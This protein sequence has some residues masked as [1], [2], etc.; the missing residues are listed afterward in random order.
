LE[1]ILA[2]KAAEDTEVSV[3]MVDIQVVVAGI[4]HTA[5]AVDSDP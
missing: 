5:E 4:V 3:P 2:V 1:G